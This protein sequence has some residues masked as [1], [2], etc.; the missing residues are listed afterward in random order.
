MAAKGGKGAVRKVS[1][2]AYVVEIEY[3]PV[4]DAADRLLKAYEFLLGLPEGPETCSEGEE[5][6]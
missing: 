4:D 2:P 5:L 1:L 3:E 6:T